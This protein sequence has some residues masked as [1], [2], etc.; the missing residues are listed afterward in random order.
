MSAG[1]YEAPQA[2]KLPDS[3]KSYPKT[4]VKNAWQAWSACNQMHLQDYKRQK[5]RERI[6]KAY[7]RF[8]P[9]EYSTL[10]KQGQ[11][12][13]S[14]VGFGMMAYVVDNALC[15]FYDMIV[16]RPTAAEIVTK[17]GDAQERK[18]YSEQ[19]SEAFDRMLRAWDT[20]LLNV[21]Q[22]ILDMLLYGKGI[23]MRED[24]EGFTTHHVPAEDFLIPDGVKISLT[25]FEQCAVRRAY[26]IQELYDKIRS[27]GAADTGWDEK[28]VMDAIRMQRRDWYRTFTTVEKFTHAIAEGNVHLGTYLSERIN[29]YLYFV[30]EFNGKISKYVVLQ[31][32]APFLANYPNQTGKAFTESDKENTVNKQG[33]LFSSVNYEDEL[34]DI[35]SFFMDCAGT[36]MWH[37]VPSLAERIFVQCRQYDFSMNAVMDAVKINMSLILQAQSPDASEKLKALVLGPHT[38]FPSDVPF[39]QQRLQLDT[40]EATDTVQFMMLDMF[41]GIGEYRIN[42]QTPQGDNVTATQA[43]FDAAESAKL[44]GTQLSRY[45]S[46]KTLYYRDLYEKMI[47]CKQGE[48]DYELFKVFKDY[49][50]ENEVPDKA[51]KMENIV[52][53]NSNMLGGSGSPSYKIMACEKT[54]SL[55]NVSPKDQGQA[56]AVADGLAAL[57]GRSNVE[58]YMPKM[59]PDKTWNQLLAGYENAMLADPT[60][61][62]ASVQVNPQDNDTYHL[63]VHFDDMQA[64]MQMVAQQMQQGNL[65][66]SMAMIAMSKLKNQMGHCQAHLQKLSRDEGKKDIMKMAMQRMNQITGQVQN[67]GKQMQA[68]QQQK[69]QSFD[70]QNDPEIQKKIAMGQLEVSTAQKLSQIQ[71]GSTAAKAHQRMQIDQQK[72]ANKIAI[73]RAAKLDKMRQDAAEHGQEMRQAEAENNPLLGYG[74]TAQTTNELGA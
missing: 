13:T 61:Q 53:I 55:T 39:I 48:K 68:F 59:G 8:P 3:P 22:D 49:L 40:K 72:A 74:E 25:N 28:A 44:S 32:Y 30:K 70:P 5:K 57:H 14:N 38:V 6:Y 51:W 60:L 37:L 29:C 58:R 15:S 65:T 31:D 36:G 24:R 52:S 73:D 26:T 33:F 16:D 64:T 10:F 67:M 71:L 2:L 41:R 1:T 54:I 4:R 66:E 34:S 46:Y 11:A 19:I 63:G 45:N 50:R 27:G 23:E 47:E 62:P 43:K 9:S 17:F 7:N 69:Q 56:N 42:Q 21:E 18:L 12:W 20:Y 35:F